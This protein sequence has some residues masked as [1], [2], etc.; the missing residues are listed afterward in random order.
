MLTFLKENVRF[1][2]LDRLERV[3]KHVVY[4]DF[5]VGP[6]RKI[7]MHFSLQAVFGWIVMILVLYSACPIRPH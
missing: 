1:D 6:F 4:F 5:I 2:N 7:I 3:Q